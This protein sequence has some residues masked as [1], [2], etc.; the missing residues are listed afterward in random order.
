MTPGLP[1]VS[2]RETIRVCEQLGHSIVRQRSK[3]IS[4]IKQIPGKSR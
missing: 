2:A 3:H 4:A 1:V